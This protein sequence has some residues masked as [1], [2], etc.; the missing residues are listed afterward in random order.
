MPI[1]ITSACTV[2]DG[3]TTYGGLLVRNRRIEQIDGGIAAPVGENQ[4]HKPEFG[5]QP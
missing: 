2:N 1:L 3:M 5:R 4:A